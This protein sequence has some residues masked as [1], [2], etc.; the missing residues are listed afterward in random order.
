MK[1]TYSGIDIL[2]VCAAICIVAIHTGATGINMVGR[3]G[4]PFFAIVS[5]MLF[6]HKYQGLRSQ[7]RRQYLIH[8]ERRLGLLFICWQIFYLPSAALYLVQSLHR[9]GTNDGVIH[10]FRHFIFPP[11]PLTNG[12]GQSWYLIG[13]LIALPLFVLVYRFL[14]NYLTFILILLLY[15]FYVDYNTGYHFWNGIRYLPNSLVYFL[16][17]FGNNS[18]PILLIYI[19]IGMLIAKRLP[20]LNLRAATPFIFLGIG[21]LFLYSLENLLL[22]KLTGRID[23]LTVILTAPASAAL[24]L[25]GIKWPVQLHHHLF[26]RRFSTFLYCIHV[27]IIHCFDILKIIL[28]T[29]ILNAYLTMLLTIILSYIAY[30]LFNYLLE[31]KRWHW[32]KWLV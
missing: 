4:V 8:F 2:K 5:S 25:M 30:L 13:M 20:S 17:P 18:F 15:I 19:G 21:G 29:Q 7:Q 16:G 31:K 23:N 3:L 28:H 9:F 1:R 32:L 24:V 11:L 22:W 26:W 27:G 10:F 6:F 14:G 12:W